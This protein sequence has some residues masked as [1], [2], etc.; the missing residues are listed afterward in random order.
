MNKLRFGTC[1][2]DDSCCNTLD[3]W[4]QNNWENNSARIFRYKYSVTGGF[5]IYERNWSH[6]VYMNT[7]IFTCTKNRLPNKSL[8]PYIGR[9]RDPYHGIRVGTTVY[10][11]GQQDEMI[12]MPTLT[13]NHD[14][15]VIKSCFEV[16]NWCQDHDFMSWFHVYNM[17]MIDWNMI[18]RLKVW[19]KHDL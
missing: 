5:E 10:L 9:Y 8:S 1:S 16:I 4:S 7:N 12:P 3:W 19:L 15:E 14:I 6:I 18:Y 13:L 11:G 2:A 17:F